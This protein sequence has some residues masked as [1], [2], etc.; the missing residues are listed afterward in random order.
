[1]FYPQKNGVTFWGVGKSLKLEIIHEQPKGS[2]E[3]FGDARLVEL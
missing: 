2:L 3:G 1:M